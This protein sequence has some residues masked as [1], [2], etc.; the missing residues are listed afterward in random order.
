[1]R[2]VRAGFARR[3]VAYTKERTAF[4]APIASF[5]GVTFPL[6]EGESQIA[7]IRQFCY[8]ALAL[9]DAGRPHACEAAMVKWMGPKTAFDVI[10]QCLFT[11]GRRDGRHHEADCGAR[12][13]RRPIDEALKTRHDDPGLAP[14]S[15]R[16][17]SGDTEHLMDSETFFRSRYLHM[18]RQSL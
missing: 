9:R 5:Q 17:L 10:H 2:G 7:A 16:I 18:P 13:R 14:A 12:T 1:M 6:V 8:P 3:G 15:I 11:F 4:N